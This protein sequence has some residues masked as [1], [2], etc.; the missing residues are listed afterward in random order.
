M[1]NTGKT[2]GFT[3]IEL[4]VVI[5][6][7]ALLLSIILPALKSAK[8][9]AKRLVS[10]SNMRQIGVAVTLYADDNKGFFPLTTHTTGELEHTWI[11]TLQ[12][13]LSNVDTVRICPADP[14]GQARL[15]KNTTSYIANEYMTPRY[16]FGQLILSDSFHNLHKLRNPGRAITVFVAADR[17]SASDVN[18]DHTHSRSW[19]ISDDR[20]E[21]W[22][23]IH[24]DIQVNRYRI[25]SSNQDPAK[26]T[27][28][29]LY[30]DNRVEPIQAQTI[31]KM[32]EQRINFAKPVQ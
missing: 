6:I 1:N 21:R 29:F 26:G 18:A 16:Q 3:L 28:L 30:A 20:K 9:M 17:W 2:T 11:Y 32:S 7:I 14:Q 22:T 12:P 19:F 13:Y 5:A 24:S 15:E 4:L 25:G 23:A 10:S 27:T 8:M 31:K